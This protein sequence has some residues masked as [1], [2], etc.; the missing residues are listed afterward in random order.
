MSWFPERYSDRCAAVFAGAAD[1]ASHKPS[2]RHMNFAA[3]AGKRVI[4]V[5]SGPCY[6]C[7]GQTLVHPRGVCRNECNSVEQ[8]R[9]ASGDDF[10]NCAWRIAG[11]A[12]RNRTRLQRDACTD[13][14]GICQTTDKDRPFAETADREEQVRR[15]AQNHGSESSDVCDRSNDGT[16]AIDKKRIDRF[17]ENIGFVRLAIE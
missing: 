12:H 8:R 4:G 14:C 3:N 10:H 16:F 13:Q 17:Q 15:H 5:W 2:L 9:R 7:C 11:A 6:L 1:R